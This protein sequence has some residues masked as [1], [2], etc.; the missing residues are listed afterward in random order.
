MIE[1]SV[2]EKDELNAGECSL[3]YEAFMNFCKETRNWD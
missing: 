2:V 1:I 3:Y